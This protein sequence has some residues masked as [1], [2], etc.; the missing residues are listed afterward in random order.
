[1]TENR[2]QGGN[3]TPAIDLHSAMPGHPIHVMFSDDSAAE[4]ISGYFRRAFDQ[5]LYPFH[6]GG[7]TFALVVGNRPP[8]TPGEDRISPSY[9]RKVHAQSCPLQEQGDGMR[10]FATVILSLL[11]SRTQSVLVLD[12]PEA[13]L[14]PP[15]ARLLG[16]FIAKERP[17]RSQLFVSTHSPDILR[18]LLGV[19]STKMRIVRLVRD[20]DVNRAKE[21]SKGKVKQIANDPLMQYS[22]VLDAM[23]HER[24]FIA[25]ADTDCM[26]YNSILSLPSIHGSRQPDA[27][28]IHGSGKHRMH[29]LSD[30][31]RDLGVKTD[32]IVDID[33]LRSDDD[34]ERLARAVGVD[35]NSIATDAKTLRH[36]IDARKGGLSAPETTAAIEKV[37]DAVPKSGTFPEDRAKEI[38][39]L[40]RQTSPWTA[41]KSGG[42][43]A[44]PN[45]QPTQ[46][47][48][49]IE[50][51]C[52]A[53]GLWIVPVGEVEGFCK[54]V[55][56]HGPSW[57][58]EVLETKKLE[59][60][61]ELQ[62]ARDFV[63]AIWKR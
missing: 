40:L 39:N 63:S 48:N 8:V 58:Q 14:H 34:F 1:M 16:E 10:A 43:A 23:F 56:K 24:A 4:R 57:A 3:S 27:V 32:V 11:I 21:L 51:A 62:P 26:F 9:V 20:G 19:A 55:G 59:H 42:K 30:A 37:L 52:A 28:F 44:L 49:A 54:S 46:Q 45:G 31:L 13:F 15:Q 50:S 41:V 60:D 7:G 33:I 38:E 29:A 6:G 5:D 35:W 47:F 53:S 17:K 12:E 18:G 36:A 25:E 61:P 2:L 22:G